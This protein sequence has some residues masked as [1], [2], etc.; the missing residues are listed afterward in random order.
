MVA[1]R[2]QKLFLFMVAST[3]IDNPAK[4][5]FQNPYGGICIHIYKKNVLLRGL[6]LYTMFYLISDDRSWKIIHTGP[7]LNCLVFQR[8]LLFIV[9]FLFHYLHHV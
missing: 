8:L 9:V 7:L 2:E 3:N 5:A 6:E 4:A 1:T